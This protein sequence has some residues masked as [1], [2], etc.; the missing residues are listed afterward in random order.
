M[1]RFPALRE[2]ELGPGMYEIEGTFEK[3]LRI[4]NSPRNPI[5]K[6]AKSP[7]IKIVKNIEVP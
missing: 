6:K 1:P 2:A 3:A 7:T 5:V 4:I